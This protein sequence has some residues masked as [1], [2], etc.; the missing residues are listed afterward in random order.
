[1][2]GPMEETYGEQRFAELWA[3]WVD[4]ISQFVH[5]PE[6]EDVKGILVFADI[7]C[8]FLVFLFREYLRGAAA[9]DQLPH[10][11]RPR[12]AGPHGAR[13]PPSLPPRAR[14]RV[15]VR[16]SVFSILPVPRVKS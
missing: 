7:L 8:Y 10:P 2:R 15:T 13:L 16:L 3:S 11:D 4:G 12:R 5:R 6:G 9:A 14:Q 1:M